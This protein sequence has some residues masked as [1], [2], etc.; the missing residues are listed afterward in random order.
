MLKKSQKNKIL[1]HNL[2]VYGTYKKGEINHKK[3]I[4]KTTGFC[5]FLC[6]GETMEKFPLIIVPKFNVPGL[7]RISGN[8]FNV[9]GEIYQVDDNKLKVLDEYEDHPNTY[10]RTPEIIKVLS[11][12]NILMK[13][14]VK[15]SKET[16]KENLTLLRCWIYFYQIINSEP[17]KAKLLETYKGK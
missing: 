12:K 6:F 15:K 14:L 9:H 5:K 16:P 8:G 11:N 17:I 7:I 10:L 13:K 2:F 4:D 1:L 3:L